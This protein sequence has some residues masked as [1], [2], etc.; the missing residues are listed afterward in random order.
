MQ[1]AHS[2]DGYMPYWPYLWPAAHSMAEAVL[3]NTGRPGR[4]CWKSA[5]VWAWSASPALTRGLKVTFSDYDRTA[6]ELALHNARQNGFSNAAA[7]HLDWRE[8]TPLSFPIVLGCDVLYE[9]GNHAR[10]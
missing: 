2:R 5:P 7:M 8:P 1:A 6:V 9:T 4:G 3:S 10:Y